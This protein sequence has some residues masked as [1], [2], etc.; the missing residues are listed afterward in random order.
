MTQYLLSIYQ[1][2]CDPPPTEVLQRV[3]ENLHILNEELKAS[4]SWV[5]TG[6]LQPRRAAHRRPCSSRLHLSRGSRSSADLEAASSRQSSVSRRGFR[7]AP[8]PREH[9]RIPEPTSRAE[10]ILSLR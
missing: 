7:L 5:F 8:Q 3:A 9:R 10:L 4:G 6:G 1:P 2:D